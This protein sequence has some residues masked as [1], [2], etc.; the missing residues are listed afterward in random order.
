MGNNLFCLLLTSCT[1]TIIFEV[2]T[3]LDFSFA[4]SGSPLRQFIYSGHSGPG[5]DPGPGNS[6]VMLPLRVHVSPLYL[7]SA[8]LCHH[9]IWVQPLSVAI[10]SHFYSGLL[11]S[12]K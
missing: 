8:S 12:W 6:G 2:M 10:F 9:C 3:A 1:L 11:E 5:T 4:Q 7:G